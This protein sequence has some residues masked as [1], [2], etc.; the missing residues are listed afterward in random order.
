LQEKEVEI[1]RKEK[2][3]E[4]PQNSHLCEKNAKNG[5]CKKITIEICKE[6]NLQ[7]KEFA[8]NKV[9]KKQRVEIARNGLCKK[10]VCL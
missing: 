5:I 8:S 10:C 4:K 3:K 9:S 6:Q 7:E 2:F 1:A